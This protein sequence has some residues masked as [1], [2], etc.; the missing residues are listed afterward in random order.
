MESASVYPHAEAVQAPR[1]GPTTCGLRIPLICGGVLA[2]TS[3][4]QGG[5]LTGADWGLLPRPVNE[6][7]EEGNYI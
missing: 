6:Q 5:N 2:S 3:S 1:T 7:I 4:G